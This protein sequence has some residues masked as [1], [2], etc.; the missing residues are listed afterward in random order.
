MSQVNESGMIGGGMDVHAEIARF[1]SDMHR[2]LD[3]ISEEVSD[4]RAD[5]R[6]FGAAL[7][8]MTTQMNEAEA[9]SSRC[10]ISVSPG[11]PIISTLPLYAFS[12]FRPAPGVSTSGM[13]GCNRG[14]RHQGLE[15]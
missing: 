15:Q 7:E 4:A 13:I 2:S 6:K 1:V 5:L 14:V 11:D 9:Y 3:L 10:L 12:R 8:A